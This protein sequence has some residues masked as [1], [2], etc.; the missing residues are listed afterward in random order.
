MKVIKCYILVCHSAL[1]LVRQKPEPSQ[2]T[3][4][5][6]AC[7]F[8]GKVLGVGCHYFPPP[9]NMTFAAMYFHV[10]TT[11]NLAEM[12]TYTP[13]CELLNA[14]KYDMGPTALLPLRRKAC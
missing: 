4:M 2:A 6:V 10:C 11:V 5:T 3:D 12:K 14:A 9:L 1:R 13:F 7:C 8:L